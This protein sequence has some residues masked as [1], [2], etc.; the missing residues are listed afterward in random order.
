M[1]TAKIV[2]L[3]SVHSA[4]DNRIYY[5]ECLS[6]A[7]RGFQV[8]IVG[9][10]SADVETN[11]VRI[12]AIPPERSRLARMTRSAWRV[13]I[14][15]LRQDADVYHF[16]DPELIPAGLLLRALGK[17]VV[18][19]IHE[20]LP[21]RILS[22]PYLPPWSRRLISRAVDR[23]EGTASSCFSALVPVTP[24]IAGRFQSRNRRTIVVLNYPRQKE[25]M[26]R[27]AA[28]PWE[29]RRP[30][31]G[32]VGGVTVNRGICEMVT[33]MALLPKSLSAVLEIAGNDVPD[34]DRP[35]EVNRL[36]GWRYVHRHGILDRA[37]IAHLLSQVRAGLVVIHPTTAFLESV[38][39][40]LFEYMAAGLPV[41]ASDFPAWHQMLDRVGC[42][43][44]VD[45]LDPQAIAAAMEYLL[46]H[47][48]EAQE[49]GRRGQAAVRE[50][51]NWEIEEKKLFDLYRE[52]LD[53]TCAE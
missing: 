48:T 45:P 25:L 2:H 50:E 16:H 20:D 35:E 8:T 43:I 26:D 42:A 6:L 1:N 44:F 33:A 31:L 9:P 7:D 32:Y 38:P 53:S 22:K 28:S 4:L 39:L 27:A 18:Y 24:F 29:T 49:M 41:I 37:G 11:H 30:S 3:T 40:K 21:K 36:P 52:L 10:H 15:A 17:K 34:H 5:R 47:P 23:F 12:K 14:E 46:T 13:Y 51:F 19:D